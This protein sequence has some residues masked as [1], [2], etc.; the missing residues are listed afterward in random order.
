MVCIGSGGAFH[1]ITYI[2]E[3]GEVRTGED[4]VLNRLPLARAYQYV[5]IFWAMQRIAVKRP[6]G[7]NAASQI[8]I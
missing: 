3:E 5:Q 2:D 8:I 6:S 1:G 7:Q 4:Y